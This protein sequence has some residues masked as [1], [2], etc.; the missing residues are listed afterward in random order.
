MEEDLPC[1]LWKRGFEYA[2]VTDDNEF[3]SQHRSIWEAF[4]AARD[5]FAPQMLWDGY[6][7]GRT[8]EAG[9]LVDTITDRIYAGTRYSF[10]KIYES[11]QMRRQMETGQPLSPHPPNLHPT[12]PTPAQL[13]Y[14]E[15]LIEQCV[16]CEDVAAAIA[17]AAAYGRR[18]HPATNPGFL[19]K[20]WT[21]NRR[22]LAQL[23][24]NEASRLIRCLRSA[25]RHYEGNLAQT[26]DGQYGNRVLSLPD[27]DR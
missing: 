9:R 1:I 21:A 15:A 10:E 19:A 14:V 3:I 23:N 4:K 27:A 26:L 25:V 20:A 7:L 8:P 13:S 11:A 12:A 24:R 22:T 2:A 18:L 6:V 5:V 16:D 17:A